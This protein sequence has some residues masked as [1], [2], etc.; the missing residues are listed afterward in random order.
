MFFFN[1]TATTE[2]YTRSLVGS[3]SS[4]ASDVYKRQGKDVGRQTGAL[5]WARVVCAGRRSQRHVDGQQLIGQA[6]GAGV[7]QAQR[8]RKRR[9]GRSF[10]VDLQWRNVQVAC[11][12]MKVLRQHPVIGDVQA[13]AVAAISAN[14]CLLYT[15]PSPRDRT[16]SRMPSSA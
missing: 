10:Y 13:N 9:A 2:I 16:R 11:G 1:D 8:K 12:Q 5:E 6:E 14:S 15:S 7:A 3:G 4:A